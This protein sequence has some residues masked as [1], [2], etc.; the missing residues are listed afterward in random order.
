MAD[1]VSET[2][3]L[4][5]AYSAQS[6]A[7][8]GT[9]A[10]FNLDVIIHSYAPYMVGSSP[11]GVFGAANDDALRKAL[12]QSFAH[13]RAVGGTSMKATHIAVTPLDALHAIAHVDWD[14]AYT[15]KAGESGHVTFRNLYFVTIASG[16]PKIFAYITPDEEAAMEE[17]GLV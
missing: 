9:P 5:E 8:L 10:D 12:P 17:H 14:F 16:E 15:N 7:A 13:Y 6:D 4:F 11:K 2:R 3:R 1:L